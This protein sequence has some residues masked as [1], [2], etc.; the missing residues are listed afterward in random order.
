MSPHF[1]DS[2]GGNRLTSC[3]WAVMQRPISTAMATRC[4]PCAR[5][6]GRLRPRR[7]N[8]RR[9]MAFFRSS[10]SVRAARSSAHG[11]WR[12]TLESS[13]SK[14]ATGGKTFRIRIQNWL[15]R[16]DSLACPSGVAGF[17]RSLG[18][19]RHLRCRWCPSDNRKIESHGALEAPSLRNSTKLAGT[20]PSKVGQK[21]RGELGVRLLATWA[22]HGLSGGHPSSG[23]WSL[24]RSAAAQYA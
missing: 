22:I 16:V 13:L 5:Y 19:A 18:P 17:S 3:R 4:V 11:T 6:N 2:R 10:F 8:G 14:T 21:S 12:V 7:W 1:A 23:S 24:L 15:P 9:S 20:L